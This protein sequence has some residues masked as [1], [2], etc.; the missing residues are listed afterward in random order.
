MRNSYY[1]LM[2]PYPLLT[3]NHFTVPVTLLAEKEKNSQGNNLNALKYKQN[4][5]DDY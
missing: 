1:L 3:L 5:F 2:N 4:I